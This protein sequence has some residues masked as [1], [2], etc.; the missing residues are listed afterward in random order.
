MLLCILNISQTPEHSHN[1]HEHSQTQIHT[2]NYAIALKFQSL[3]SFQNHRCYACVFVF[4]LIR[5]DYARRSAPLY[6]SNVFGFHFSV[7]HLVATDWY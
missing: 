7:I 6:A 2:V 3:I 1:T 4:V 5:L